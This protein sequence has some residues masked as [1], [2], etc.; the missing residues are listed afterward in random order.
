MFE[1]NRNT[2]QH[3]ERI[4]EL[5]KRLGVLL[6]LSRGDLDD[7]ELLA[8]LH[9]IGKVGIDENILNKTGA[10]TDEET[11]AIR[12]HPEIGYRIAMASPEL[13]SVADYILTHQE[14]WDG[15]G[16]PLGLCGEGIP[17]MS[18]IIAV[19]DSFDSI[20]HDKP[21][22]KALTEEQAIE[23]IRKNAGVQF[24]PFISEK[25]L[26]LVRNGARGD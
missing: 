23:E 13:V 21:Y 8:T 17:Y 20:T 19:V 18:R 15:S 1:K 11:A 24:D 16:Y 2:Q 12:K 4:A 6:G 7:L 26:V 22:R 3:A 14:R 9:D 25:F 10:L 5:S